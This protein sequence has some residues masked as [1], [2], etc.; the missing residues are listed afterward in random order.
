MA[1][2]MFADENAALQAELHETRVDRDTYRAW[3][4]VTLHAL[5]AL[6]KERDITRRQNRELRERLRSQEP[7]AV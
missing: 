7:E 5:A 6:T 2:S 3:F 1:C 4:K